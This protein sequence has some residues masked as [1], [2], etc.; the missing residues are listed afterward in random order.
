M[1]FAIGITAIVLFLVF[2][3]F[4]FRSPDRIVLHESKGQV[5]K[6]KG[7]VY[8]RHFSLA[9]PATD[10]TIQPEILA[11]AKGRLEVRIRL[12]V[13]VAAS[14][15][16]LS[17]LIRVA[18]WGQAA[19]A[20]A[21]GELDAVCDGLVRGFAEKHEI[22]ELS[23]E[24]LTEH[25]QN[26][27][28][29]L[30]HQW[31][32][33]LRSVYVQSVEP[34]DEKIAAAMRRQEADRILEQTE[35][36]SQKARVAAS[37]AKVDADEKIALSEH[38]LEL[39]RLEL[40]KV[41]EAKEADLARVRIEEELKSRRMH[42]ELDREEVALLRNNPELVLLT[43]QV[44]RLAEASQNLKSAKTVVSLSPNDFKDDSPIASLLQSLIKRLG[45]S[46]SK[47]MPAEKEEKS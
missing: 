6:R 35:V 37:K 36:L 1:W 45:A 29:T 26:E 12:S 38:Q 47:K 11:E 40:R 42:L 8:P 41:E 4:R 32:L 13:T 34:V 15:N 28:K 14:L 44:A 10:H 7:R 31:G 25:L 43:P 9:V 5:G 17:N 30:T 2:F 46:G 23:S 39:R 19:V 20:K 24:K 21:T 27:L 22:E 3:E 18:G 16:H 33:E